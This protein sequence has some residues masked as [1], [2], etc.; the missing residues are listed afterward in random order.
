MMSE[1]TCA[2]YNDSDRQIA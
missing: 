1:K 2:A